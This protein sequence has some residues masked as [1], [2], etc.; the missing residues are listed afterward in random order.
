MQTKR[1]GLQIEFAGGNE[2][3]HQ[4]GIVVSVAT[5]AV[6]HHGGMEW[7]RRFDPGD[8]ILVQR[9]SHP[10]NRIEP[11]GADRDDFRDQRVVVWRHRVAGINV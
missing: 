1:P 7:H 3:V 9:A 11:C 4:T 8:V 10:I 5:I 6:A 2:P